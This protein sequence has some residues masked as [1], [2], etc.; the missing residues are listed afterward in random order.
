MKDL[1][2]IELEA[3]GMSCQYLRAAV[4]RPKAFR[5]VRTTTCL[6]QPFLCLYEIWRTQTE[7]C[8]NKLVRYR[9][10][11]RPQIA[12]PID[13]PLILIIEL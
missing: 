10:V 4:R 13:H 1:D 2:S 11:M 5:R 9:K 8:F 6:R 7:H 12:Y 3:L